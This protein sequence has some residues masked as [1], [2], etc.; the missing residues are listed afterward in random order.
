MPVLIAPGKSLVE[1]IF[2]LGHSKFHTRRIMADNMDIEAIAGKQGMLAR[3][4]TDPEVFKLE[5]ERIFQRVWIFVG[6]ESQVPKPGNFRRTSIGTNEVLL[7]RQKDYSL[8]ILFNNCAHRGTRLCAAAEGNRTS[9]VC[10]YHAWTFDL[11]GTLKGVPDVES[12]PTSFDIN[13]PSLHLKS[14]PRLQDYRGFIFASLSEQGPNLIDYLGK[15]TDAIDNLVDR[16]PDGIISVDG[17]HFRVRYSGNWKLHHENANDTV[18]PGF[19]HESSVTAARQSQKGKRGKAKPIDDG[20]TRGM[21]ASN[22]LSPKDWNTIE[23]NGMSNGHSFM[24]GF[25]KSG[26]LAPQQDDD[27]T[28]TYR[29]A[30]EKAHGKKRTDAILGMDRFNNLIWPNLNVNSQFHQI[31]VV[32]PISVNETVIEGYCFRLKG[33]PEE[34]FYRSI[35]FL[36]TLVSP[37][38]MIFSDDLEIFERIQ[39]GLENGKLERLD[40]RRGMATDKPLNGTGN[41]H[42][43]TSSELPLRSQTAAWKYWMS[44]GQ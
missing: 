37:A 29:T 16:A 26:L 24:G 18:H 12:Y 22:G 15:M 14:A 35:R 11:D 41:F 10:P 2:D 43:T 34:I 44:A 23:L 19:V 25:Y 7:V 28:R 42:S 13:D 9:F 40:H 5:M 4:Y 31:R 8:K 33:A 36:G 38:S 6:H 1:T 21:M 17:G 20:Q 27:V 30:L 39:H 32:H 3:A